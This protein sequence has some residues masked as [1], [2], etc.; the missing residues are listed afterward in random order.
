MYKNTN[1]QRTKYNK[2]TKYN[3]CKKQKYKNSR[4]YKKHNN[5]KKVKY[6]NALQNIELN[7]QN[8]RIIN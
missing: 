3:K 4:S 1:T 6:N 7:I 5:Y 8:N 2:M